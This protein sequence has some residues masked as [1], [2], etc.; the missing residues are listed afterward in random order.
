MRTTKS[1]VVSA[2][3]NCTT[4]IYMIKFFNKAITKTE[5]KQKLKM[6]KLC[7]QKVKSNFCYQ[8]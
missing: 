2:Q 3:E 5:D 4:N 1:V 6:Q 8:F 7:Y